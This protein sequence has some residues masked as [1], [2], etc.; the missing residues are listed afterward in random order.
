MLATKFIF[1]L[2]ILRTWFQKDNY[3]CNYWVATCIFLPLGYIL[4]NFSLFS[5]NRRNQAIYQ[6][7]TSSLRNSSCC[8]RSTL[9]ISCAEGVT[10]GQSK[11]ML[12]CAACGI[13]LSCGMK[14]GA[15]AEFYGWK[16]AKQKKVPIFTLKDNVFNCFSQMNACYPQDLPVLCFQSTI[17][18][19]PL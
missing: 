10:W 3:N 8:W 19:I 2:S 1:H 13:F 7:F 18:L 9:L 4:L 15:A 12:V 14:A 16:W 17:F 6:T 11:E 5:F